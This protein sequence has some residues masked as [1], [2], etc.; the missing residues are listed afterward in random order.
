[1]GAKPAQ[2]RVERRA[3]GDRLAVGP[4]RDLEVLTPAFR[5]LPAFWA[6]DS[7]TAT[8]FTSD[9][10]AYGAFPS[11][12][13]APMVRDQDDQIDFESVRDYTH[14]RFWWLRHLASDQLRADL[15]ALFAARRVERIAPAY[16]AIL[17]G[18]HVVRRHL[19]HM[20]RLLTPTA[21]LRAPVAAGRT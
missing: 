20:R 1:V 13:Y 4:N 15:D 5:M 18:E 10:F 8:L 6:Y 17:T 12:D 16:G 21:R 3:V 14:A 2:Q 9:V 19:D 11:A 7:E